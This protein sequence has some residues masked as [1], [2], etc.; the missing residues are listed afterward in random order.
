VKTAIQQGLILAENPTNAKENRKIIELRANPEDVQ[1]TALT[2]Y[3][4]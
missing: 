1:R 4:L 3:D 2:F